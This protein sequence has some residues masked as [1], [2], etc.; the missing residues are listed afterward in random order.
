MLPD[1]IPVSMHLRKHNTMLVSKPLCDQV[2]VSTPKEYAKTGTG[3]QLELEGL[4][5]Q[6]SR[7]FQGL[8]QAEFS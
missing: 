4:T 6:K 2:Q 7:A 3:R 8:Q 1:A 5:G